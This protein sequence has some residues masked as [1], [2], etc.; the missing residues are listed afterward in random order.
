MFRGR[1]GSERQGCFHKVNSRQPHTGERVRMAE[2]AGSCFRRR[3]LIAQQP[4]TRADTEPALRPR[5]A[6]GKVITRKTLRIIST[7]EL[8]R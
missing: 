3:V 1:S 6:H 4:E 7:K 5:R 2:F 8:P